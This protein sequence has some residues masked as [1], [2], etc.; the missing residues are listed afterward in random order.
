[1]N[2]KEFARIL[3]E[4]TK[5]FAVQI[6]N[7]SGSLP[8][9]WEG[10]VIRNQLTKSGTSIG[11]NYAEAN[12]ASSKQDFRSKIRICEGE[13]NE[14]RYWLDIADRMNW[15]GGTAAKEVIK[16]ANELLAIFSTISKNTK[17]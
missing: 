6:I 1:M 11:A 5:K 10:R 14:T 4:R 16:E 8:N 9:T 13:A 2:N 12:R 17:L 15:F 7:V 3:E